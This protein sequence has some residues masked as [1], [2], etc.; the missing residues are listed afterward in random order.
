M[1]KGTASNELLIIPYY[2]TMDRERRE[3]GRE[4]GGRSEER[5]RG[6]ERERERESE[7]EREREKE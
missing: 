1:G 6:R 7:S 5:E 2:Q 4:G 3:G